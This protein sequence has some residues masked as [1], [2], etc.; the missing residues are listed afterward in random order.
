MTELRPI[1]KGSEKQ[2]AWAEQIR[3]Q[4][5]RDWDKA[6]SLV[7][8][9][10]P[11]AGA[12]NWDAQ[13]RAASLTS[14]APEYAE[15]ALAQLAGIEDAKWWIDHRTPTPQ[16]RTRDQALAGV[17]LVWDTASELLAADRAEQADA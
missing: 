5:F 15:R 4:V 13:K 16:F 12:Y 8:S 9:E 1:T 11:N 10:D 6:V 14:Q 3:T 2:I 7:G 17:Q